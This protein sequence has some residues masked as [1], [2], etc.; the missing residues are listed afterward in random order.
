MK[1]TETKMYL[2]R[3]TIVVEQ[4]VDAPNTQK[5]LEEAFAQLDSDL[6]SVEFDV[7]GSE[8]DLVPKQ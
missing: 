7:V 1:K 6:D 5:A 2:V 4:Y 8:V 3:Y